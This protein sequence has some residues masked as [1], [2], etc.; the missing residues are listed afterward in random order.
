M[1]GWNIFPA[2]II[3]AAKGKTAEITEHFQHLL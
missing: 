3:M 2:A 1:L